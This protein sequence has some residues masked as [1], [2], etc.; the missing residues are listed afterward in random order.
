MLQIELQYEGDYKLGQVKCLF[1][2]KLTSV[3]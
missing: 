2:H 3:V 1:F